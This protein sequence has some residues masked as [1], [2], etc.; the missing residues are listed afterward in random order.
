MPI[1]MGHIFLVISRESAETNK[2]LHVIRFLNEICREIL[3]S[4]N[5]DGN[6]FNYIIMLCK[7]EC[8]YIQP[9]IIRNDI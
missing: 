2:M 5:R 6:R 1:C 9:S 7:Q 4:M 3:V 8:N